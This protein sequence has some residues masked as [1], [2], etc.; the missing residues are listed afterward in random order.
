[1]QTRE[2]ICAVD[3][4]EVIISQRG[5]SSFPI[6]D[7]SM[8]L[9]RAKLSDC[10]RLA[11]TKLAGSAKCGIIPRIAFAGLGALRLRILAEGSLVLSIT[12]RVLLYSEHIK[13]E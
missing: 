11:R 4:R 6:A 8:W 7:S 9:L 13:D 2:N 10:R 3:W 12:F 5:I 1:V